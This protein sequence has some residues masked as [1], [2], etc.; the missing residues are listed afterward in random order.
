MEVEV[1]SG[2]TGLFRLVSGR[3]FFRG[4]VVVFWVFLVW[5]FV[6]FFFFHVFGGWPGKKNSF[7]QL[8]GQFLGV[9]SF[10]GGKIDE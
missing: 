8:F 10:W 2:F 3:G 7:C 6:T 5:V 9:F 4:N 1:E